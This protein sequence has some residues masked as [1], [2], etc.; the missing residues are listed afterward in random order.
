MRILILTD[1]YN[2]PETE[3]FIGLKKAGIDIELLVRSEPPY[4]RAQ[5]AGLTSKEF[6]VQG[7][8]DFKAILSLRKE[9]KEGK[10][11]IL[12]VFNN[13]AA[14][15]GF[16]ASIGLPIKIIAYRGIVGNVSFFSPNSWLT[17]LNPKVRRV[18][19][20]AE[21]IRTHFLQ[22]RFLG[23]QLNPEKFV[24]IHKG[25]E[26]S[27]Y[28]KQA[29]DLNQFGIPQGAFVVGFAGRDR[30]RKGI[31]VLIEAVNLL[32]RN[33]DVH[34]LLVGKMYRKK[35]ME[36][37]AKSPRKDNIHLAGYRHDAPQIAAACSIFALP[38]LAR[39]GLP[40][41][42]IEAMAYGTPALVSDTGG[43]PELIKQG[44]CGYALP[45]GDAEKL[46]EA[47]LEL[48]N[49]PV[50]LKK[51]GAA[52]QKQIDDNFNNRQTVEKTIALYRKVMK[53]P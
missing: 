44:E 48:Y 14:S 45:A 27:W 46:S 21:A 19:C 11:D 16:L 33:V 23:L 51:M 1:I 2:R 49:N 12:H 53:N 3:T 42:V 30:P 6:V 47:I 8:F 40:R 7:R 52:A 29:T 32:P 20:V 13:R 9:L 10:F 22:M 37:I 39:E 34:L 43:N 5:E 50:K 35:L 41:A 4:P 38:S 17:Y 18:V 36:K 26:L 28:Q 15:V 24:T 31:E 25:H